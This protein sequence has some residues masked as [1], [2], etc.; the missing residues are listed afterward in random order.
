MRLET[1]GVIEPWSGE[2]SV[3]AARRHRSNMENKSLDAGLRI[4]WCLSNAY[5]RVDVS[6]TP[7]VMI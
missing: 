2:S 1:R 3:G 6:Q 5:L 4:D 7:V